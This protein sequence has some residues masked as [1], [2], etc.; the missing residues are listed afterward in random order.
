MDAVLC[1]RCKGKG[2][3][4]KTNCPIVASIKR[5]K[6]VTGRV[7]TDFF[8]SS[9]PSVFVGRIG[10]PDVSFGALAPAEEGNTAIYD[11]PSDWFSKNYS[12]DKI[13][14]LRSS[15]INS[16]VKTN[17]YRSGSFL[18]KIQEIA[19]ASKPLD[20]EAKYDRPIK[21]D[22]NVDPYSR[23]APIGPRAY[24]KELDICE[25]PKVPMKVDKVV[26]DTDLKAVEAIGILD[27]KK[28]SE[29]HIVKL[30]STGLLGEEKKRKLVP[31][32]WSITA[33]DDMISKKYLEDIRNFDEV[34]QFLVFSSEYLGNHFEIL[35]MPGLW[36]FEC[37]EV[38]FPG[39]VWSPESKEPV[40][41]KDY[42]K[43]AGRKTYASNVAGGYYATR[44]PVTRYLKNKKMQASVLSLREIYE[45]Y[46]M[47]LG[48]WILR[49]TVKDA[50][51][52]EPVAFDSLEAALMHMKS[53]L[54]LD[55]SVYRAESNLLKDYRCQRRITDFVKDI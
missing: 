3:C 29:N 36:A 11:S 10:Y 26:S 44:L 1:A 13:F 20:I 53:R 37:I 31:T 47:P 9:P 16:S 32:R 27:H 21:P 15:L 34:G 49:E 54:R 50:F 17:V 38:T 6:E 22:V 33:T 7:K 45:E 18:E 24:M 48:V 14:D 41:Y 5:L 4:G 55:F 19:L 39:S 42:E 51:S 46:S 25:N 52:K 12:I 43:F 35:L 40:M 8:G 2:L 30:L 23:F 28:L